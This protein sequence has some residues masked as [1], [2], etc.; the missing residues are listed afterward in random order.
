MIE[1]ER[2]GL[3]VPGQ[4]II[5]KRTPTGKTFLQEDGKYRLRASEKLVHYTDKGQMHD[6]DLEPVDM[7]DYWLVDK[8]PYI[9]TVSKAKPHILYQGRGSGLRIEMELQHVDGQAPGQFTPEV[10]PRGICFKGI[11]DND[12]HIAI[13]AKSVRTEQHIASPQGIRTLGWK[14]RQNYP[15]PIVVETLRKARD[16][17]RSKGELQ[18]TRSQLVRDGADWIHTFEEKFTGKK[19]EKDPVTR[20]LIPVD[21]AVYP[22]RV[23]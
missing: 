12:I 15:E 4:E 2:I 21:G 14:I 8:A 22:V 3:I 13:R 5:E 6:I 10:T 9:L 1:A 19:L 11:T 16:A 20:R 17:E 7:G 23:R 18:I